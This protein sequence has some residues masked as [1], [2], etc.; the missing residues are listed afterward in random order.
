[1]TFKGLR[2]Y[3]V[4][5]SLRWML[6]RCFN[7]GLWRVCQHNLL[8]RKHSR[9]NGDNPTKAY[10]LREPRHDLNCFS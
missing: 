8:V 7:N 2:R 9:G 10:N 6:E 4:V 5:I 1:M 3:D